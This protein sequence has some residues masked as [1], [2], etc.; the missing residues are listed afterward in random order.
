MLY[1]GPGIYKGPGLYKGASIYNGDGV[2]KDG[3]K[4]PL[5][6][7]LILCEYFDKRVGAPLTSGTINSFGYDNTCPLNIAG[8]APYSG[9]E[10]F[11]D[12]RYNSID[13]LVQAGTFTIE[14]FLKVDQL[15]SVEQ[16]SPSAF[17]K[18][19]GDRWI[20][21]MAPVSNNSNLLNVWHNDSST[22]HSANN[23]TK[24]HHYEISVNNKR[25]YYFLDGIY[26]TDYDIT[27][28]LIAAWFIIH[29]QMNQRCKFR[30]SQVAVWDI[31]KHTSSFTVDYEPIA[32]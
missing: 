5:P 24:W 8:G 22:V 11:I 20:A 6:D 9:S 7:H 14:Y 30:V 17:V 31:C 15:T 10:D 4:T 29:S 26:K 27:S 32:Y 28:G 13:S 25:A 21:A 16:S 18:N 23:S 3:I 2:Y 12:L 1:K 19:T